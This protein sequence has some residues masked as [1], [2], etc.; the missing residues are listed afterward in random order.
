MRIRFDRAG[1]F[2]APAM[3]RSLTV[4]T[5]E[6]AAD[7]A[8]ELLALVRRADIPDAAGHQSAEASGPR[9]DALHYRVI[10]EDGDDSHTVVASDADMPQTLRPLVQWLSER[11][12]PPGK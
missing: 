4:D 8:E 5:E 10:V 9:P 1:G 12:T 7:E 11:S 3:R 2:A 6:L